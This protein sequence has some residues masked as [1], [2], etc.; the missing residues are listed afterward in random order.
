MSLR[1]RVIAL[2]ALVIPMTALAADPRLKMPRFD[3]LQRTA[4]ASVNVTIGNG[5]LKLASMAL[6]HERDAE[7]RQALEVISGLKAIYVRSYEFPEDNMYSKEDVESVRAQ[8]AQPGWSPLAQIRQRHDEVEDV[9]VY[10][11]LENDK[12]NGFAIVATCPRKF[13]IVNIVGSIDVEK[14]AAIEARFGL[15]DY[16]M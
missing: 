8:L 13:T 4:T 1:A 12:I 15:E 2:A 11:S 3:H 5:L 6:K 10:V 9:D 7:G 14:L 16:R